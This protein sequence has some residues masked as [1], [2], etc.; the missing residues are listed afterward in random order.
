MP[1]ETDLLVDR[2]RLKRRVAFWRA[3]AVGAVVVAVLAAISHQPRGFAGR[4]HVTRVSIN[5]IITGDTKVA[6]QIASLA[7]DRSVSALIVAIDS[8]GGAVSGGEALH[9]AIA[10][11]AAR[12]PVVAVMGGEAASA[13]YMIAV[14]AARIF[15]HQSTITGSIGVLME[16]PEASG[17]LDKVGITNTQIVSGVMKGQPSL[18][19]PL[20][21]GAHAYLQ[22]LVGD[23]FDQFVDIVVQGR[24]MEKARV[25][26]LADGRAYTGRQALPLGLIDQFGGEP[27]ARQW[28]AQTRHIPLAIP[29]LDLDQ[30]T[31]FRHWVSGASFG[32]VIEAA[33]NVVFP[34][35][36]MLDGPVALW[37]P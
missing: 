10:A 14:P 24:H 33:M 12:K 27:D 5:G 19:A 30:K 15:A 31:G 23:L 6:D 25:E 8:P 35:R 7:T 13:G 37:Q 29:V 9:D 36:V 3:V 26:A 20:T 1:L 32:G 2:A 4:P 22:G 34:Q 18:S 16:I 21:P 28:L 17:L 11:V